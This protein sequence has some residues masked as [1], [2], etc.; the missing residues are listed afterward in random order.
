MNRPASI[1]LFEKLYLLSLVVSAVA[2]ALGGEQLLARAGAR[3]GLSASAQQG[4]AIGA[5]LFTFVI[6]LL[7]L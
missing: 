5:V 2:I 3:P 7:L 4:V 1:V 6:A